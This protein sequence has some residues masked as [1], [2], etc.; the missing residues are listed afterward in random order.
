MSEISE[1]FLPLEKLRD[2][3]SFRPPAF[4][5]TKFNVFQLLGPNESAHSRLLAELFNPL[6]THGKGGLY[7]GLLLEHLADEQ[8]ALAGELRKF[9]PTRVETEHALPGAQAL[10]RID[11]AL[12][13]ED[14]REAVIIENKIRDAPD[15]ERQLPRYFELLQKQGYKVIAAVYLSRDFKGFPPDCDDVLKKRI[16]PVAT[17]FLVDY[18]KA[19]VGKTADTGIKI[20]LEQYWRFLMD[21]SAVPDRIMKLFYDT[22]CLDDLQGK[23]LTPMDLRKMLDALPFYLAHELYVHCTSSWRISGAYAE[24]ER[25]Q[26]GLFLSV[27]DYYGYGTSGDVLLWAELW[28]PDAQPGKDAVQLFPQLREQLKEKFSV[29]AEEIQYYNQ[30]YYQKYYRSAIRSLSEGKKVLEAFRSLLKAEKRCP[31]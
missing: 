25:Y 27:T 13:D 8:P 21:N 23:H 26:N 29:E 24:I 22:L 6:G 15:M 12:L 1:L 3:Q 10:G 4:R 2:D 17:E 5:E 7:G 18:L 14:K 9:R 11:I 19:C 20:I 31:C 30:I 16:I 28:R